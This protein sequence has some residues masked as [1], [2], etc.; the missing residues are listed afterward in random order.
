MVV[1]RKRVTRLRGVAA[2]IRA[3]PM[4]E[5]REET[6]ATATRSASP[7]PLE[8]TQRASGGSVEGAMGHSRILF[9]L[10]A[11]CCSCLDLSD[12]PPPVPSGY[13]KI[14]EYESGKA[15]LLIDG[16]NYVSESD[17]G[18]SFNVEGGFDDELDVSTSFDYNFYLD[19]RDVE[20]G[21]YTIA[22]GDL[23]ATYDGYEANADCGDGHL[24]IVGRKRYDAGLSGEREFMWGTI[25]LEL[26][27]PEHA[28]EDDPSSIEISGRFSSII[29][30]N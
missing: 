7:E 17:G 20:V 6:Q 16:D 30:R 11:L 3:L 28:S 22:S 25:Q 18:T 12:K 26:C 21:R 19:Y 9:G 2:G 29:T 5:L 15:E 14:G 8:T 23:V 1:T 24:E 13:P 10:L 27:P 4:L